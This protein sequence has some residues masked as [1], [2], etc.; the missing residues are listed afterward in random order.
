MLQVR[1]GFSDEVRSD[2]AALFDLSFGAK[3]S[4]AIPDSTQRLAILAE[5]FHPE[6][7]FVAFKSNKLIGIAGFK[8]LSGALTGRITFSLLCKHLGLVSAVRAATVLALFER[9]LAMGQLLMDGVSVAPNARGTG[10]GTVLIQCIQTLGRQ[11][12]H[13]TLRLDV[14]DTNPAARRLYERL[15]FLATRTARFPWLGRLLGFSSA[16]TMEFNLHVN[17]NR[18][19]G[20]A[21]ECLHKLGRDH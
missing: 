13:R 19:E 10:I 7:C 6:C 2:A 20:S 17:F 12:G 4:K 11:E 9:P 16:T 8:S 14:I 3:L 18:C 21:D 5:A 15:G 1:R